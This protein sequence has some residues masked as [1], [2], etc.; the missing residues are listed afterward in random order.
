MKQATALAATKETQVTM[1]PAP[2]EAE[3]ESR[4]RSRA[5]E[6][7]IE[8]GMAPGYEV[9]DWLKAEQEILATDAT[10]IARRTAA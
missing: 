5:Y 4:I 7:Y 1:M 2:F 9:E 6:L 8:R 10:P 3:E